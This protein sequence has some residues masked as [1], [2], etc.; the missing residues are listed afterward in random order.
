MGLLTTSFL[1]RLAEVKKGRIKR[2]WLSG[3]KPN[4]GLKSID[5]IFDVH[6]KR[7]HRLQA[8]TAEMCSTL[9]TYTTGCRK[10]PGLSNSFHDLYLCGKSRTRLC[11]GQKIIKLINTVA[12]K[13]NT[14]KTVAQKLKVVFLDNYNVSL[15]EMIIPAADVSEQLS[16]AGKRSLQG[17]GI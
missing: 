1:K 12:A 6:I 14:D 13:V 3:Y 2:S 8:S 15:A 16:T 4:M 7:I 10:N 9:W 11:A 17:P 5:S